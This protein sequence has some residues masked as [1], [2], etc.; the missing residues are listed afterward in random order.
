MKIYISGGITKLD[1]EE[2][3]SLFMF[4]E[5]AIGRAGHVPLN[6]LKL[7]DQAEGRTYNEYLA[8]ALVIMLKQAEAVLFLSNYVH[9]KGAMIERHLAIELD[10]PRYFAIEDLPIGCDWAEANDE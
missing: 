6:P 3:E 2:A 8:D 10:I 5:A 1:Y 7:V 4:A 9:S